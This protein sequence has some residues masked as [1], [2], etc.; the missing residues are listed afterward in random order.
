MPTDQG[1]K[2]HD[3]ALTAR[4][5]SILDILAAYRQR[6]AECSVIFDLIGPNHHSTQKSASRRYPANRSRGEE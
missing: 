6:V 5:E 2:V 3:N 1:T 4:I